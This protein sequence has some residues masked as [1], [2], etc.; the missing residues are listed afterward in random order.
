MN[1]ES[2]NPHNIIK[3]IGKPK[4][5]R[6]KASIILIKLSEDNK[7]QKLKLN[8]VLALSIIILTAIIGLALK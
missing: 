5:W 1:E 8:G 2:D 7:H 6:E 4:Q 3:L